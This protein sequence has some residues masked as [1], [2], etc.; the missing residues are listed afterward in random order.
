MRALLHRSHIQY[1]NE[2]KALNYRYSKTPLIAFGAAHQ[3]TD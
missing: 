1:R 3:R 2:E